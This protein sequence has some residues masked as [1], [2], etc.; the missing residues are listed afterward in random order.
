MIFVDTEELVH[1]NDVD[2]IVGFVLVTEENVT[3]Q[4][5]LKFLISSITSSEKENYESE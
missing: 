3:D 5:K 1:K 2:T 4:E